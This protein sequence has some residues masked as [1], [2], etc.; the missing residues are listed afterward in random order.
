MVMLQDST[1]ILQKIVILQDSDK[2]T[3]ILQDLPEKCISCKICKK[4]GPIIQKSGR[5][6]LTK[7]KTLETLFNFN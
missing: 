5:M 6:L 7:E 2:R 3:V 4:N 1:R